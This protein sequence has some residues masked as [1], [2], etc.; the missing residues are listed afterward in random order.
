MSRKSDGRRQGEFYRRSF[1]SFLPC[2]CEQMLVL[3]KS[4]NPL[5]GSET[6]TSYP[7]AVSFGILPNGMGYRYLMVW[8][9]K[10]HYGQIF[11]MQFFINNN[12]G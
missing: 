4:F 5:R 10:Q 9:S 3:L 12:S 7:F 2:R 8:G 1:D 6:Y 11:C